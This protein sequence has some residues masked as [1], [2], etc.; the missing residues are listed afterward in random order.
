MSNQEG[1]LV[2]I[3]NDLIS[4]CRDAEEGY[5]KAAKGVHNREWSDR[6]TALSGERA[7]F[8]E[9]I[10]GIISNLGAEPSRDAHFGGILHRGWVD[11]ETRLRGKNDGE[12][13]REC[14]LGDQETLNHYQYALESAPQMPGETGVVIE[15]HRDTIRAE[16]DSLRKHEPHTATA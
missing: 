12:L 2:K 14:R 13:L 9:E 7:A 15:R 3:L 5:A 16:I 11:L 6:L 4:A 10:S 8:A 1:E